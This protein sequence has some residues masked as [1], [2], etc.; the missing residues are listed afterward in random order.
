MDPNPKDK[1][2]K[3]NDLILPEELSTSSKKKSEWIVNILTAPATSMIL[4]A[5]LMISLF[6]TA[7]FIAYQKVNKPSIPTNY[8][9]CTKSKGSLIRESYPAVCV[10]KSGT[11]FIQPLS[12]EE[13]KLLETPLVES[14]NNSQDSSRCNPKFAIESGPELTASEAYSQ[15]CTN[16]IT[17]EECE[18]VDVYRAPSQNFGNT[19]GIPDCEWQE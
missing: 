7:F 14:G 4:S 1:N 10:T 17:K 9:E 13:Q 18:K 6:G 3:P 2:I 5:L 12:E 19:D 16:K 8:Q 15:E 11:E